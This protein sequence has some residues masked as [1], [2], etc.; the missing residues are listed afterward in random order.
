MESMEHLFLL[1]ANCSNRM[2]TDLRLRD[3]D[4]KSSVNRIL[5][6]RSFSMKLCMYPLVSSY[7]LNQGSTVDG[8][9][10]GT[11]SASLFLLLYCMCFSRMHKLSDLYLSEPL[12]MEDI[13]APP[14]KILDEIARLEAIPAFLD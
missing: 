13:R 10:L 2:G 3:V 6:G 11:H 9:I 8:L 1:I 12:L 5:G 14:Q 7:V 4:S